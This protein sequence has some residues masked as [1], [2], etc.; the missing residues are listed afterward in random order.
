MKEITLNK[1]KKMMMVFTQTRIRFFLRFRWF[2]VENMDTVDLAFLKT[3][4]ALFM[5]V[6]SNTGLE[7]AICLWLL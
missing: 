4:R 2:F 6:Q 5:G 1:R 3:M 7:L